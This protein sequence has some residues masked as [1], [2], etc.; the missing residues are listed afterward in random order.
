MLGMG[1]ATSIMSLCR[2]G[3]DAGV[4]WIA[5]LL[6][7]SYVASLILL[8]QINASFNEHLDASTRDGGFASVI[9]AILATDFEKMAAIGSVI[10]VPYFIFGIFIARLFGSA[11]P[12]EYHRLYAADLIGAAGGC[13]VSVIALDFLGFSGC[14]GVI[15]ISTFIGAGIFG[16]VESKA[17]ARVSALLAT[18]AM[19]LAL[20]PALISYI[21]PTPWTVTLA[22]NYDRS[23]S[24]E[25][26][27][28]RWNAYSRV[29]LLRLTDLSTGEERKVYAHENGNGWASVPSFDL[30]ALTD[31]SPLAPLTTMFSP[32]RVL[33]LFAGVGADMV[34]IDAA[35][36][37]RCDIT[38]V[39]I[40]RHMVEHAESYGDPKLQE[41]LARPNIRLR[42]AEAREFLER[43]D[44]KYDAILLSWWGAGA[45]TYVGTTG[46][47]AQYLYT[48]EAFASLIDHLTPDGLIVLYNGSKAQTL[49]TLGALY[50]ERGW[51]SLA[52][53]V[54]ILQDKGSSAQARALGFYDLLEE[55]RLVLKPSGFDAQ[56]LN[57]LYSVAGEINNEVVAS[58]REVLPKYKVYERL[59]SGESLDTVN[60]DLRQRH[61]VELS[62]VTD[63]RPFIDDLVPSSKYW[64]LS[65]WLQADSQNGIWQLTKDLVEFIAVLSFISLV[66]IIGPLFRP[67]GPKRSSANV[68]QILYFSALGA[69]F[70]AVEIGLVVKFGMILGHPSYSI[71]VVLA[72]LIL[73]TGI[74][75]LASHRLFESGLLTEKRA[76]ALAVAYIIVVA[77]SYKLFASSLIAL[78]LVFKA[79]LVIALIFPLGFVLGQLFPQGLRKVGRTDPQAVPWAWA[80]NNTSSTVGSAAAFVLSF[81][82]G[83]DALLYIGAAAYG[84]II[85][86]PLQSSLVR[87]PQEAVTG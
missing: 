8:T 51:G 22:R 69:G 54:A 32:K 28:H 43:D 31:N 18:A 2:Q 77:A 61:D 68:N 82:L 81:P 14:V 30:P 25:S 39:E 19:A 37:G 73:S 41:F 63:D 15:L 52:G 59:I 67:T 50:D 27:W 53:R 11:S 40:N 36:D 85:L 71:A 4:S 6:G 45:S 57:T 46:K 16:L 76:A 70:M 29:A 64:S 24:V 1:A 26:E 48:K 86:V 87:T 9:S 3:R 80:I 21:E 72:S 79:G 47:L 66:L 13:L 44:G 33:V 56:E 62:V 38:G 10:F 5:I 17:A 83:F 42:T 75:A 55:M 78:P 35:C 7:A 65:A 12:N 49:A 34:A 74:G 84:V 58:P 60:A 20:S 23:E